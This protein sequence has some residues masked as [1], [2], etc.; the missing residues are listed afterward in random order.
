MSEAVTAV[1]SRPQV[2]KYIGQVKWFN[3][4]LGYGFITYTDKSNVS[5]DVFVHHTSIKPQKTTYRTLTLGEYVEFSLTVLKN[6]DKKQAINV[7]GVFNGPL[8]SDSLYEYRNDRS[9]YNSYNDLRELNDYSKKIYNLGWRPTIK[10]SEG[11]Q[12]VIML[13]KNSN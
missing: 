4:T 9:T 5:H 1:E 11:L 10:F 2:G 13:R 8:L 6:N 12:K 3:D 7:T